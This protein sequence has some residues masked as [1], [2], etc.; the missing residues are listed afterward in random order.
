MWKKALEKAHLVH[1][2]T[3]SVTAQVT[4]KKRTIT[5]PALKQTTLI[6]TFVEVK[7]FVAEYSFDGAMVRFVLWDKRELCGSLKGCLIFYT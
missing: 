3:K 6:F 1:K 5:A 2:W 7:A 4:S